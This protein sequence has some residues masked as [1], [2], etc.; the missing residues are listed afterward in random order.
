MERDLERSAVWKGGQLVGLGLPLQRL[1]QESFAAS[2][3]EQEQP[4]NTPGEPGDGEH[5]NGSC[6]RVVCGG[7]GPLRREIEQLHETVEVV[8]GNRR[9]VTLGVVQQVECFLLLRLGEGMQRIGRVAGENLVGRCAA[10]IVVIAVIRMD[11]I[12]RRRT[13]TSPPSS[14]R[15]EANWSRSGRRVSH[16][17]RPGPQSEP[18]PS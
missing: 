13:L 12:G 16:S 17:S 9:V 8:D 15:A 3:G 18:G 4:S 11:E 5:L 2:S 6:F 1:P 14:A 10:V 7:L